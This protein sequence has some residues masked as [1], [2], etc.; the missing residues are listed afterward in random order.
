MYKNSS[1]TR[2]LHINKTNVTFYII[3]P[4]FLL[5]WWTQNIINFFLDSFPNFPHILR[6]LWCSYICISFKPVFYLLKKIKKNPS[7]FIEITWYGFLIKRVICIFGPLGLFKTS[8]LVSEF[9]Q[10][11]LLLLQLWCLQRSGTH[12]T[13]KLKKKSTFD[14]NRKF[15]RNSETKNVIY[16]LY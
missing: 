13:P 2:M 6:Y 15:W 10:K 5:C 14:Q 4:F 3:C 1:S 12:T 7:L 9:A 11:Q 16:L 8:V